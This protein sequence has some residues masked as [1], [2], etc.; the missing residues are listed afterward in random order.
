MIGPRPATKRDK[1]INSDLWAAHLAQWTE[2]EDRK[3]KRKR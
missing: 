1:E 3:I 2:E